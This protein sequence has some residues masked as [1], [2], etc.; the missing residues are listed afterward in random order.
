MNCQQHA[1]E[2]QSIAFP[3]SFTR[4][5]NRHGATTEEWEENDRRSLNAFPEIMIADGHPPGAP[6]FSIRQGLKLGAVAVSCVELEV[7]V[8]RAS[9]SQV[10]HPVQ[11][12]LTTPPNKRPIT[13]PIVDILPGYCWPCNMSGQ[14]DSK[15]ARGLL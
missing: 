2:N 11:G 3:T 10:D 8:T 15:R 5:G 6:P 4:H 7:T 13:D 1:I 12:F 9:G 14:Q